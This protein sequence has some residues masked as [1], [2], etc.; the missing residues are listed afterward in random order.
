M[1]EYREVCFDKQFLKSQN[2]PLDLA[3][4]V[5]E[6][7]NEYVDRLKCFFEGLKKE[8]VQSIL[9]RTD[10]SVDKYRPTINFL[11]GILGTRK[12]S[13]ALI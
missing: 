3:K 2:L 10:S 11:V 12:S 5:N 7:Y 13:C 4:N 8:E 9:K 6:G 1:V